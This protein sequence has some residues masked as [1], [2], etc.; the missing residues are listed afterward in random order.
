MS[1]AALP[2]QW[3][4]VAQAEEIESFTPLILNQVASVAEAVDDIAFGTAKGPTRLGPLLRAVSAASIMARQDGPPE[5]IT[6]P[7]RTFE[8]SF[9]STP[10]SR[11]ACSIAT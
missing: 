11:I 2:M 3:F 8:I 6:I 5:P 1:S 7:V 4:D 10:E 9:S